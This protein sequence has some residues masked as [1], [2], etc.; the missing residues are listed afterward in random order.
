MATDSFEPIVELLR[1]HPKWHV[2]ISV[3]LPVIRLSLRGRLEDDPQWPKMVSVEISELERQNSRFPLLPHVLE[4]L[5]QQLVESAP[6][7]Q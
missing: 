4:R 2:V 3:R 7:S 1:R 6:P 5:E